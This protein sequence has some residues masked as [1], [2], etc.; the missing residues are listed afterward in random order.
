MNQSSQN[1]ANIDSMVNPY[2]NLALGG[3][4]I[5]TDI[6]GLIMQKQAMDRARREAKAIDEREV[7]Y[8]ASRDAVTDKMNKETL[9]MSKQKMSLERALAMHGLN[10]DKVSQLE[11]MLNNNVALQNR[12]LSMW[13]K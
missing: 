12:T 4:A 6:I 9:K 1:S 11:S 5:V 7:A 10:R 8:R 13:G 3:G 2:V